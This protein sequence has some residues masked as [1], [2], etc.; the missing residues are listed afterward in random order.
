MD[1][2][3]AQL[4]SASSGE[5]EARAAIARLPVMLRSLGT[6]SDSATLYLLLVNAYG[7]ADELERACEPF[8]LARRLATTPAHQRDIV[9]YGRVLPCAP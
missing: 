6:A 3:A 7:Q 4:A 1:R 9:Q 8:R 5:A 2:I